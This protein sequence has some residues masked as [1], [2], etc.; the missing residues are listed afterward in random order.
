MTCAYSGIVSGNSK[1]SHPGIEGRGCA[2]RN[3]PLRVDVP[4]WNAAEAGDAELL[5]D[6]AQHLIEWP[7]TAARICGAF[8]ALSEDDRPATV[9]RARKH[10]LL[11]HSV[12]AVD[13]LVD[14][15]QH[16][17]GIAEIRREWSAA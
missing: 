11:E 16:Q 17:N 10:Q 9:G 12:D 6:F 13:R 15:L 7:A 8:H 4:E 5:G 1:L 2:Q 3:R 14:I